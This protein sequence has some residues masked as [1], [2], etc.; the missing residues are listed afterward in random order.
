MQNAINIVINFLRFLSACCRQRL[1]ECGKS[2]L[3]TLKAQ[4]F[5]WTRTCSR[6]RSITAAKENFVNRA[7]W[8]VHVWV[9]GIELIWFVDGWLEQKEKRKVNFKCKNCRNVTTRKKKALF[10]LSLSRFV[11]L[12][13]LYFLAVF[14]RGKLTKITSDFGDVRFILL[15]NVCGHAWA[16]NLIGGWRSFWGENLNFQTKLWRF[17]NKHFVR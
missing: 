16:N 3:S 12:F 15:T 5:L 14:K 2:K 1:I 17:S 11:L 4:Q 7:V 9:A 10:W 13:W 8:F 6:S